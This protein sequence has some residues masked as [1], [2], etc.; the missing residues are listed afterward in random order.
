[1]ILLN[2]K[3]IR[4]L[5]SMT[6]A[7]A[8][9]KQALTLHSKG[10]CEVPLR[11]NIEV[12]AQGGASLFM[13]AY[14]PDLETIGV[15]IVSVFP[16]NASKGLPT[17]PAKVVL[18]D[19]STG[20]VI[21]IMDGTFLTQLRTGAV[22]G[23][24]T[25][26]LAR[27]DSH[28]GALIG[29]GGQ[30][31]RQLEAMLCVRPLEEVR[32]FDIDANRAHAFVD[33]MSQELVAYGAR[34][35]A[36]PSAHAAVSEAD[37]VTA[38]TTSLAPVFDD[39]SIRPGTHVNGVGAYTPAMQ[40]LPAGLIARADRVV[41]DTGAALEEAG[42]LIEPVKAGL[43]AAGSMIE[44]GQVIGGSASGRTGENQITVFNSVGSAV[45]DVVTARAIYDA[46][47]EQGRGQQIDL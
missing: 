2:A 1:M 29:T 15:K 6:E 36:S 30:A 21:A 9:A 45:L 11:T 31:A 44:L 7:V 16:G 25:D 24:A 37:V 40:E 33:A 28:V 43:I 12:A 41:V 38:V 5:L 34:I 20:D 32:V 47:I 10:R 27:K 18:M 22:Q 39:A 19:A 42:D 46:A 4:E 17:V 14:V 13:P 35:V 3:D 26:T 8:A 23:A